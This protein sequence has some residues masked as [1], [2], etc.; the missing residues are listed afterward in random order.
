VKLAYA[1][2]LDPVTTLFYRFVVAGLALS[3]I[4]IF[5]RSRPPL[6]RRQ[7]LLMFGVGAVLNTLVVW[8]IFES[9][10]YISASVAIMCLYLYPAI[11]SV[12]SGPVL[13][14]RPGCRSLIALL[15]SLGGV[16]LMAWAPGARVSLIGVTFAFLAAFFNA[17][18][19]LLYKK[20]LGGIQPMAASAEILIWTA[21]CFAGVA[22]VKGIQVNLAPVSW[23]VVGGLTLFSTII[24]FTALYAGLNLI[25]A[26]RASILSTSE[27]LVTALL[28][29]LLLGERLTLLQGLGAALVLGSVFILS[30]KNPG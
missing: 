12:L 1:H 23:A 15:F 29:A 6:A 2:G 24:P 18:S 3:P 21:L 11:V 17:M 13:G 20:F 14:E 28:A 10:G 27:P 19:V 4:L 26:S 25:Q 5:R 22:A 7:H 8:S 16:A 9:L 30:Y